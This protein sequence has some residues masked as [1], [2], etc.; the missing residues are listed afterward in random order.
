MAAGGLASFGHAAYFGLGAYGAALARQV[1]RLRR[2]LAALAFGAASRGLSARS[3][4]G[5]FCVRLSGVYFAMLTLAFA[6]IAWSVAFQWVEVTGG[7]NG[8]LGVWPAPFAA[9]PARF[10]WLCL[11]LSVASV[12]ALRILVFSPFGYALRATRD[13]PLRAEAIGI[14]RGARAMGR[15]RRRRHASR[16]LRARCSPF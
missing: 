6:Q 16:R 2:W 9:T 14:D 3:L 11:A 10:F 8:I 13:S 4:F 12:A 1:A 5:W 7:D 15:L